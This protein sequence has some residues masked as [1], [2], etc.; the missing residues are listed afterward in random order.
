M[1]YRLVV[2]LCNKGKKPNMCTLNC[3]PKR[4]FI[5]FNIFISSL[6]D[7]T[8]GRARPLFGASRHSSCTCVIVIIIIKIAIMSELNRVDTIVSSKCDNGTTRESARP[9]DKETYRYCF[10]LTVCNGVY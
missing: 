2:F 3:I 5:Y 7:G 8:G 6:F 10:R 4:E 1:Y 9:S